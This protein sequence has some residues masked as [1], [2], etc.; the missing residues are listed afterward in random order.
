MP[1][2]CARDVAYLDRHFA[3]GYA[4]IRKLEKRGS[5]LAAVVH[6]AAPTSR[7]PRLIGRR[8]SDCV[9]NAKAHGV[10]RMICDCTSN[11]NYLSRPFA[12]S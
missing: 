1:A 8:S 2:S 9:S 5:S 6:A 7:F 12:R 11:E 4:A 3:D 10:S